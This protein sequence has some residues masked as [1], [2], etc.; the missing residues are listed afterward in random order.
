MEECRLLADLRNDDG[1]PRL[2]DLAGDALADGPRG[3]LSLGAQPLGRRD[4][5][6]A[7]VRAL[8]DNGSLE[9]PALLREDLQRALQTGADVVRSDEGRVDVGQQRKRFRIG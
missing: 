6:P 2:D 3:A 4:L 1:P 8:Q 9:H 5:Q 7:G